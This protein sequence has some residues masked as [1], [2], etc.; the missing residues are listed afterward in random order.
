MLATKVLSPTN[1]CI[2]KSRR[3]NPQ[4]V[5]I[6]KLKPCRA[7]PGRDIAFLTRKSRNLQTVT[8]QKKTRVSRLGSD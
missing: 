2:Q 8:G 5:H 3:A 1:V 6:D 4:V 7:V